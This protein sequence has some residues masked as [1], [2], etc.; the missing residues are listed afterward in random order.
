MIGSPYGA[1]LALEAEVV[2]DH[3][4]ELGIGGLALDARDRVAEEA[5]QGLDIAAVGLLVR[6][7]GIFALTD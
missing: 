1:V 4:D 5:L 7:S 2:G 6:F 3:G